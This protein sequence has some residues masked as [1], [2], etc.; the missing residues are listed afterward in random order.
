MTHKGA[1]GI[2]YVFIYLSLTIYIMNSSEKNFS[3]E[4]HGKSCDCS[5]C[6]GEQAPQRIA[7]R[8]AIVTREIVENRAVD[9]QERAEERRRLSEE[10]RSATTDVFG[11]A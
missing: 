7:E 9:A 1:K 2:K 11:N 6:Y 5:G 10:R 4:V 8:K 3:I